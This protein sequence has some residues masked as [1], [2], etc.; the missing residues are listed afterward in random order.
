MVSSAA[1]GTFSRKD[2]ISRVS[3]KFDWLTQADIQRLNPFA[4]E[5]L[6]LIIP[7]IQS[8]SSDDKKSAVGKPG[9]NDVK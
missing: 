3:L 7:P 8:E 9:G 4:W 2:N 1:N 5:S 6:G